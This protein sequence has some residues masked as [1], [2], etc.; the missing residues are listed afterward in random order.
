MYSIPD[1]VPKLLI[2]CLK[3]SIL[4]VLPRLD[5]LMK[6]L[7]CLFSLWAWHNPCAL[8]GFWF[9]CLISIRAGSLQYSRPCQRS[10]EG[11]LIRHGLVYLLWLP[12]QWR[13]SGLIALLQSSIKILFSSSCLCGLGYSMVEP[14]IIGG[15]TPVF[16]V[17]ID[18]FPIGHNIN[19]QDGVF[20]NSSPGRGR[21]ELML[22]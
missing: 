17:E 15:K 14:I 10:W 21:R 3:H 9:F 18:V 19:V 5:E 4:L 7:P 1:R 16:I 22:V 11:G 8:W 13:W 6:M 12:I 2:A 20:Q